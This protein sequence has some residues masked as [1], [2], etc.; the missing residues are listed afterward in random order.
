[1][2][3]AHTHLRRTR[4]SAFEV[5]YYIELMSVPACMFT[6]LL[7]LQRV[8]FALILLWTFVDFPSIHAQQA[9]ASSQVVSIFPNFG[10]FDGSTSVTVTG[11]GF[12]NSWTVCKFGS[13]AQ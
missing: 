13:I 3:P 10:S 6:I 9:G 2:L 11:S 1:M 12:I 7:Q 4:P 5:T 8:V